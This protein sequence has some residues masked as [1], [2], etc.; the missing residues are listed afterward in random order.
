MDLFSVILFLGLYYIRPQEWSG[1]ANRVQPVQLSMILA[2][3]AMVLKYRERPFLKELLRTPHDWMILIYFAW[4]VGTAPDISG[5]FGQAYSSLL[6]YLVTVQA[7]ANIKRIQTYLNWWSF[8]IFA[9]VLMA[10]AGEFQIWDP[11]NSYDLTHGWMKGRLILRTSI[12]N[13]PNALG[14]SVVPLVVMLYF[15]LFWKR[16]VFVKIAII[17]MMIFPLYCIYLTLSKGAYITGFATV[18]GALTYRRPKMVQAFIF[19]AAITMGWAS[20]KL[21][22]RME[23]LDNAS[24]EGGIQGRMYAFQWGFDKMRHQTTGIGYQRFLW[25]FRNE[26]GY[27]KAPHSSYVQIGTELGFIGLFLFL[28]ILYCCLRTLVTAKTTEV[29]EERVRR[30]LF[31]L[32]VSF[33]VSSW[34]VGWSYR[35][36]FFLMVAVISAFHRQML[37]RTEA[38]RIPISEPIEPEVVL[39][40]GGRETSVRTAE[41]TTATPPVPIAAPR[42]ASN[43]FA[44]T[45][46][47]P[48]VIDPGI[49]WN[50]FTWFDF[51]SISVMLI[52]TVKFWQ[53]VMKNI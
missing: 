14:H 2:I 12:F 33:M 40:I 8:F 20:L 9:V 30:I 10:L 50:R 3:I 22:P 53:Y 36:S 11:M 41:A 45:E 43:K 26:H 48:E 18:I 46:Y 16:P 39:A 38:A 7:L 37:A 44:T 35:A 28:G 34:M 42:V 29:E 25:D 49:H 1:V 17:P 21:L 15:T 32:L 52:V 23:D 31:V 24:S 19:A 6:F 47:E 27:F 5:T 51:A 13:N 4:V